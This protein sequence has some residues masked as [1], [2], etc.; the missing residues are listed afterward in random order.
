MNAGSKP[1]GVH[2]PNGINPSMCM[3]QV[4]GTR[5]VS[6]LGRCMGAF[7]GSVPSSSSFSVSPFAQELIALRQ[8]PLGQDSSWIA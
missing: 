6:S 3:Y 2:L 4:S 1:K 7:H 8:A 5:R